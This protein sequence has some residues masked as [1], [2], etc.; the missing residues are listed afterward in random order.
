MKVLA[1]ALLRELATFLE[2]ADVARLR[3]ACPALHGA[4][5][6]DGLWQRLYVD[7]W[8]PVTEC[9]E[10][11]VTDAL[12]WCERF[13]G[14]ALQHERWRRGAYES[15]H[16]LQHAQVCQY[17]TVMHEE[18]LFV[19]TNRSEL[20]VLALPELRHVATWFPYADRPSVH[21][22]SSMCGAGP[23]A[24]LV[25]TTSDGPIRCW[26]PRALVS[27]P[28]GADPYASVQ[29]LPGACELELV[30]PSAGESCGHSSSC[31]PD[32]CWAFFFDD[33]YHTVLGIGAWSVLE[34]SRETGGFLRQCS[35]VE[36]QLTLARYAAE[37]DGR[38]LFVGGTQVHLYPDD[39]DEAC[40]D[41]S[42]RRRVWSCAPLRN[43]VER[44]HPSTSGKV[45][46]WPEP[47]LS[48]SFVFPDVARPR[49]APLTDAQCRDLSAR[50]EALP[51]EGSIY[52]LAC[53][54]RFL[55]LLWHNETLSVYDY[56]LPLPPRPCAHSPFKRLRS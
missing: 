51:G 28:P 19:T 22:T 49:S 25:T 26:S 10:T 56:G 6:H 27:P 41:S 52:D 34:W 45:A 8:G 21:F 12:P 16:A 7:A 4:L 18:T 11:S 43:F 37:Y 44:Y 31:E 53:N 48:T 38:R 23:T 3:R 30:S 47:V 50:L 32:Y 14:R 46:P 40:S 24:R 33:R 1:G 17:W 42:S 35:F 13:A 54:E 5:A 29:P 20:L 36:P 55:V 9:S 39:H 2:A 15:T